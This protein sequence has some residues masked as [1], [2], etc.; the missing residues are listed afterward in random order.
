MV[1]AGVVCCGQEMW[2]EAVH[3]ATGLL[4]LSLGPA[5]PFA[6]G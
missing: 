2:L 6:I 5:N 4:G 1:V 3:C